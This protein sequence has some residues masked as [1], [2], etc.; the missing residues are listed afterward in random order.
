MQLIAPHLLEPIRGL[1]GAACLAGVV[2]GFSVWLL[3]WWGHRFWIVL[4]ATVTAGWIGFSLGRAPGVT[5]LVAGLLMAVSAG[6]MALAL[7][8]VLAFVAGGLAVSAALQ[9]L[10]PGGESRFLCFLGGGLAGLLLFR[11]WM[12]TLTSLAGTLITGYS[13]VCLMDQLG[14]IDAPSWV[15]QRTALLNWGCIGA[16]LLGLMAQY[17][18]ERWRKQMRRHRDE[19]AHF[20]R[21]E[22]QLH[23]ERM[24]RRPWWKWGGKRQAA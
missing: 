19:R 16:T 18:L 15:E 21:A 22:M 23:Q 12:M 3:G 14:K 4:F 5:P 7:A 9:M 2:L 13:A 20:Q 1:S 6:M 17:L 8:R 10:W 11:L 24:R